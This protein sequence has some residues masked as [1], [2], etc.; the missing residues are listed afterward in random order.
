MNTPLHDAAT[1]IEAAIRPKMHTGFDGGCELIR[2]TT[3]QAIN[4]YGVALANAIAARG[5]DREKLYQVQFENCA[6]WFT[7]LASMA[8]VVA[9]NCRPIKKEVDALAEV[10]DEL[11]ASMRQ[12]EWLGIRDVAS[13]RARCACLVESLEEF[14]NA[15]AAVDAAARD[16]K[17]LGD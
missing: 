6:N 9:F 15:L 14:G 2:L 12:I 13:A 10:A 8:P 5:T 11:A 3:S 1:W 17:P 16:L 4:A 7:G